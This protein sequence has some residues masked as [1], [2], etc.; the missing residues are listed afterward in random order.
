[1]SEDTPHHGSD[2]LFHPAT[3]KSAAFSPEER[4]QLGLRG[5]LPAVVNTMESQKDRVLEGV[6]RK[7]Y[8]I[9]K[10]IALRALQDRNERLFYRTLIDNID[11]LM[12]I[13]YTPTV[14]QA[15]KEFAHIFRRPRG[16]YVTPS[17]RGDIRK[18][19]DNWPEPEARVVVVTDGQRILGLGDLGASGM[20]IPIGKLALYTACSGIAPEY[21]LP[22]ML[23]VGTDNEDLLADPLYMG[24]RERRVSGERYDELVEELITALRDKWPEVL[25]Q[26]EDFLTPNAY[27]L[28]R[29]YRDRIL[30]FNDD[31]QGTAAVALSGVYASTRISGLSFEDL[32]IM[33]LGAGSA[34]TGIADLMVEAFVAAGLERDE[35]LRRLMFVDQNG[36]LVASR[37]DLM[38]HN[39]PYAHE[40]PT[41]GFV[42]ALN[43]VRPHVLIGATGAPGT[44]TQQVVET[45][46]EI[47]EHPTIF[48]LSN[49]TSRA[50]CTADQ[51]YAWSGGRA[52][53]ASG[54][55]FGD[56]EFEG[57]LRRP[58]QGN[59]AYIFPGIGL[60]AVACHA[61]TI[62][63]PMFLTAARVLADQVTDERLDEGAIYPPLSEIRPVSAH[64]AH[65]VVEQAYA[66]GL[67]QFPRPAD[68][69]SHIESQMYDP[70]YQD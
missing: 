12:P 38:E 40:G 46:A 50:E 33:F 68:L 57:R 43:Q 49:P 10:Y 65:A 27:K 36:L 69:R 32:R 48:A 56:V 41:M 28:L 25:I 31:I 34:A 1:M 17:D 30:C 5:L 51:A 9:E 35:A 42:D 47:N 70:S 37:T 13:V 45:M 24:V 18:N 60:G 59:N 3:N 22:I 67:A 23:D 7:A 63:D 54:S 61:S 29:R 15:C 2:L 62:S 55:P 20:G 44:F 26:F 66:E 53:F 58:G 4:Q 16:F 52:I 64:I 14:G 11:E 19:L 6:R 39:L 8:D 21:C